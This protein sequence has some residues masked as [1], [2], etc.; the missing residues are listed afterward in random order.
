MLAL[1]ESD[2]YRELWRKAEV[3]VLAF[4]GLGLPE[5]AP[6]ADVWRACQERQIILITGNRN[7][8]SPDSLENTIRA[9]NDARCLPVITITNPRRLMQSKAYA[10]RAAERLLDYLLFL[11]NFRGTGRLYIP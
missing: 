9:H 11:E 3:S 1:L 8:D 4:E 5:T 10:Q 6:D 2:A 7:A